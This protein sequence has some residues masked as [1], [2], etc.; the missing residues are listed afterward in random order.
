MIILLKLILAHLI[1]DFI[2]QPKAWV[3]DKERNKSRS[4]FLYLHSLLHGVISLLILWDLELWI[5]AVIIAASHMIIDLIK[6]YS[7][8]KAKQTVWFIIDQIAHLLVILMLWLV[9]I[10]PDLHVSIEAKENLIVYSTAIVFLSFPVAVLI[11]MLMRNWTVKIHDDKGISLSNAGQYIGILERLLVF[12]FVVGGHWEA[13]GFLITA[14]S[15]F[16]FGDMR[17]SKDR[18]L[19]EY[20]LIG[21][22]MSFGIALLTGLCVTSIV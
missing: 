1:A 11:K 2:L 3:E 10:K 8:N 16:R 6:A 17:E 15:V 5:I 18:K 20:I 7:Q 4:A 14:K 9:A 19:T 12:V 21:T 13:V 22:L